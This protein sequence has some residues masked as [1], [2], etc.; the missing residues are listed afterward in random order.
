MSALGQYLL[1]I[2]A[3]A[4]TVSI[5]NSF[6]DKKGAIASILKLISGLV[7]A[8]VIVAPWTDLRLSDLENSLS[9]TDV[10]AAVLVNEGQQLAQSETSKY[11]IAKT[12][13]YI[14]DKADMLGL[15]ISVSIELTKDTPTSIHKITIVGPA[16]PYAKQRIEQI[17]R[18]DLGVTEEN[19]VWT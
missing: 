3:T 11:I 8:M 4:I 14:L 6:V 15:R 19:L 2:V 18:E 13:A 5:S 1:S 12:T 16:S 7:L 17:I 10:D 9:Y